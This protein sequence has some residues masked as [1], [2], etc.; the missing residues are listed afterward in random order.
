VQ[1]QRGGAPPWMA[2]NVNDSKDDGKDD[3][4]SPPIRRMSWQTVANAIKRPFHVPHTLFPVQPI[5]RASWL[6]KQSNF[7]PFF[8][9]NPTSD[10]P[11]AT[12]ILYYPY[13]FS[14]I[15]L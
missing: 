13:I 7:P 8:F 3:E 12:Q 9:C 1:D 10:Q 2:G 4:H 11:N 15:F 6:K 14:D 5:C